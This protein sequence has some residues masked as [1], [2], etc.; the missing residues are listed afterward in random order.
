MLDGVSPVLIFRINNLI[1]VDNDPLTQKLSEIESVINSVGVP[2]PVYLD[3][4]WS[5]VVVD[6]ESKAIDIETEQDVVRKKEISSTSTKELKN[7]RL[8]N[9][10]TNINLAAQKDSV[11]L[12]VILAFCEQIVP[13]IAS[14]GYSIDYYNG[15]ILVV[16]SLLKSI[17]TSASPNDDLVRVNI[18]LSTSLANKPNNTKNSLFRSSVSTGPTP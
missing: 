6:D 18:V 3:S 8:L 13:L 9:T 10:S 11:G 1:N 7:Q 12:S 17:S 2:I 5:G 15:P 16:G 4:Q 14:K